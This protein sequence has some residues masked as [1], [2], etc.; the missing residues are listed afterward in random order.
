VIPEMFIKIARN[1]TVEVFSPDH[2]RTF[3][4]IDDAVEQT[5]LA[6]EHE[7]SRGE[8][9]NV[10]ADDPEIRIMDLVELIGRVLGRD[11]KLVRRDDTI[12]STP[13][14]CPDMS[15]LT[16][17]TNYSPEVSLE[18]GIARTYAWYRTRIS[19]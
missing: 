17:L 14:R 11:L 8:I 5:I 2:T 6:C 18:D 12:G 9:L 13:R 1:D 7:L 16:R 3:C 4:Y 19:E 10:G 15:K